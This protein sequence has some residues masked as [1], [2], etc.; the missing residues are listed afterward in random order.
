MLKRLLNLD[1]LIVQ[2]VTNT[3]IF[4]DKSKQD[5]LDMSTSRLR[6][7]YIYWQSN[8]AG[9]DL[10]W[11]LSELVLPW[12]PC[13]TEL[14]F[15]VLKPRTA[16]AIATYCLQ[17]QSFQSLYNNFCN[18]STAGTDLHDVNAVGELSRRCPRLKTFSAL[19][20]RLRQRTFWPNLGSVEDWKHFI[21]KSPGWID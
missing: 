21:A 6:G 17:F 9:K 18:D 2:S 1:Q 10:R 7:L 11:V 13:L 12:L 20:T 19:D 5:L 14:G 3:G 8:N 16:V 15:K 4:T